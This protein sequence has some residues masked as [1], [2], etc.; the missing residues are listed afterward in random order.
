MKLL[1]FAMGP[2][3]TSHAYALARHFLTNG[4]QPILA[5]RQEVV[6]DFFKSIKPCPKVIFT[7]NPDQLR[8]AVKKIKPDGVV[9]CNSKTFNKTSFI[10]NHPWPQVPTFTLDSNWLFDLEA[11][12]YPFVNWVDKYFICLPPKVFELGF[13]KNGGYFEIPPE[14]EEKIEVVGLI[15][16]YEKPSQREISATRKRLGV[17]N[18]EKLIFCYTSGY[19]AGSRSWVFDKLSLIIE[20]FINEEKKIKVVGIGRALNIKDKLKFPWLNLIEKGSIN[21]DSFYLILASADLVFQHQG[22]ATLAQAISARVPA[23]ANVAMRKKHFYPDLHDGEVNPFARLNLCKLFHK[24]TPESIIKKAIEELLY[25]KEEIVKMQEA[26]G[27]AYNKGESI[28]AQSIIKYVSE[29]NN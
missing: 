1:I 12:V 14:M 16:S 10:E 3:E 21:L 23:I 17:M 24:S 27:K 19:G 6:Y 8:T 15:P 2:G 22:L 13:K 26:Q 29:K 11:P 4:H 28:I 7:I 9:L 18:G 25:K 5:L 20:E